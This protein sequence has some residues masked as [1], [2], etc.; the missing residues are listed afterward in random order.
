M[1]NLEDE[2][3]ASGKNLQKKLRATLMYIE[4]ASLI[5]LECEDL[6]RKLVSVEDKRYIFFK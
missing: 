6:K 2:A 3:I 4:N 1:E 5:L